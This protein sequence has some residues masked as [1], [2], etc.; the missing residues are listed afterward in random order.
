M[1]L[2]ILADIHEDVARVRQALEHF[3]QEDIDQVVFLGD[4]FDRG[5]HLAETVALLSACGAVG[6]WGNHDLGLCDHPHERIRARYAGPVF[7][8]MQTLRPRLE[9]DGCLFSHGLPSW[10]PADP[11]VYYLGAKVRE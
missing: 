5:Q 8:F 6:V 11:E 7:D 4:L 10:D 3:R 9:L 1:K 2:G